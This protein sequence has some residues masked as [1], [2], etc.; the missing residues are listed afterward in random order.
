[1]LLFLD[2]D[3]VLHPFFPRTDK[4]DEENRH[5]SYLP[6]LE[7]WLRRHPDAEV[8]ISSSWR[9]NHSLGELKVH[10]SED[11]RPRII[12]TTPQKG[13]GMGPGARQDEIEAWLQQHGRT[14]DPWVALD[15]MEELFRPQSPLVVAADG[16]GER[17]EADLEFAW[18]DSAAW[19]R[20]RSCSSPPSGLWLPPGVR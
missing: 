17:E 12:G 4:S 20:N 14:A 7:A 19:A 1:M 11:I 16:F 13:T 2:F 10:F 3:G 5:F 18:R 9:R 6:R 15:D 8:V